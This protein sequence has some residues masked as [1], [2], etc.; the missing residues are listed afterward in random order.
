MIQLISIFKKNIDQINLDD[1]NDLKKQAVRESSLIEYKEA[2][3]LKPT[4]NDLKEKYWKLIKIISGFANNMGGLLIL[5]IKED[6]NS[7]ADSITPLHQLKNDLINKLRGLTVSHTIPSISLRI[8]DIDTDPN[9]PDKYILVLKILEAPGP[10]MYVNSSD[11]DSYKYFFRYNEDTIPAD[12]ATVRLLFSKKSIEEKLNEYISSRDY[13]L[14]IGEEENV[15]SWISIPY[16]F[17]LETFTEINNTTISELRNLYKNLSTE[18]RFHAL[19][20]N[21]RSCHHGILFL[22]HLRPINLYSGFFE[23]QNNGYIE[24][25]AKVKVDR[26]FLS[27]KYVIFE[28]DKFIEY[29]FYF[30][31]SYDYFGDIKIIMSIK[32]HGTGFK[33]GI[34]NIPG[35]YLYDNPN[36]FSPENKIHIERVVSVNSLDSET[37]RLDIIHDFKKELRTCFGID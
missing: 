18:K 27:E 9:N 8:K 12:H 10:V 4:R 30:Y 37:N 26:G 11:K 19:L 20:G 2:D 1:I 7:C 22:H 35:E 36:N 13:G 17:P 14:K 34:T 23:I 6:S 15:V 21:G 5:G 32:K 33:L 31:S 16:Q 28:F 3:F 25:K 29:L 24:F